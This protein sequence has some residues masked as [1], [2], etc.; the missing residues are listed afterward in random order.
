MSIH[1]NNIGT[2]FSV[3]VYDETNTLVNV[4]GA[5]V[6]EMLFYLPDT[7]IYT[8]SGVLQNAGISGV[9]QYTSVSGDLNQIGMW[10]Y[11]G[12]ITYGGRN[13]YTDITDFRVSNNIG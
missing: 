2:V 10:R 11:Q 9:M 3:T 7:T 12:H 6:A 4:S 5:S 13:L 1:L 8:R